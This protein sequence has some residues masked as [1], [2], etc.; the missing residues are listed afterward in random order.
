[1]DAQQETE[2]EQPSTS[3]DRSQGKALPQQAEASQIPVFQTPLNEERG[4]KRDREEPT[5]PSVS[6]QQ[7][8][9]K[10]QRIDPEAEEEH[11]SEERRQS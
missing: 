1:M 7:A 11:I 4:R 10:R 9:A 2:E 6:T 5:P 8:E 3:K